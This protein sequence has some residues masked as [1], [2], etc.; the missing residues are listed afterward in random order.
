MHNE[1]EN[2]NRQEIKD[3]LT[4]HLLHSV[5]GVQSHLN[6]RQFKVAL[7]ATFGIF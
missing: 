3:H 4:A 1:V 7:N 6:F 5:G 2:K